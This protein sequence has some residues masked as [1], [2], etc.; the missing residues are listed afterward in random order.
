VVE[1]VGLTL[2]LFVPLVYVLLV[3]AALLRAVDGVT[4][5]AQAAGRAYTTAGSS[6]QG[7]ADARDAAGVALADQGLTSDPHSLSVSC[8]A[9]P[10]LTPG[11]SVATVV[12]VQV[13]LPGVP[14]VL[15]HQLASVV[16]SAR[17]VDVV[18]AFAPVRP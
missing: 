3:V 2:V 12:R 15:G 7:W 16:V 6:R 17:H 4:A 14:A 13:R 11:A 9:Q 10:C 18:D 8:T 5:A 1:F